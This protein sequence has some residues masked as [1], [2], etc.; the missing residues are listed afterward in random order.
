MSGGIPTK[1][2]GTATRTDCRTVC[3]R[4]I[5]P[6]TEE[7]SLGGDPDPEGEKTSDSDGSLHRFLQ[8]DHTCTSSHAGRT[9]FRSTSTDGGTLR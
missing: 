5:G 7:I 9:D 4:A 1:P 6:A 8:F 2:T 3:Q